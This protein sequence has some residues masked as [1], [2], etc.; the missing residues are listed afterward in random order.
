MKLRDIARMLHAEVE[1]EESL[2]IRRVGKIEEAGEGDITFVANP[3]Y[4]RF[5]AS[6]RASAVI[7]GRN[8]AVPAGN[9][10]PPALVRVDDPYT[11]FL[12]VLQAFNPPQP[13]LPP[14][15]HPTAV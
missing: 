13:L 3:K 14:G 6:T 9:G 1:G 12:F 8:L 10:A 7:V 5:L 2:E 11:S 4:A 15:I